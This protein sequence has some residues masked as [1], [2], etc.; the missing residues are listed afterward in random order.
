[1]PLRYVLDEHLRQ[2]LLR[3][4]E[5]HNA[6]GI[7]PIDVVQVG[8]P[9]DLPLGTQDPDLLLWAERNGR[10][11]ITRDV[12][13]LPGHLASHLRAGH[14]SPGVFVIREQSRVRD[15]VFTLS[16]IAHAGDAA[17]YADAIEYI[18]Y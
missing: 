8:D 17:V 12:N 6:A 7:N 13:T 2:R 3:A 18:P 11:V 4:I 15:I 5:A 16:L 9:P 14:H 10:I 1:M